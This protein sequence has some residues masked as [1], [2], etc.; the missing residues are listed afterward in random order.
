MP[1]ATVVIPSFDHGPTLLY[2][3]RSALAQ[4][5][6]DIEVFVVGDGVPDTTREIM[7]ELMREDDRVR[8]FDNPKALSRG[9][10]H[11]SSAL[12]EARGEIVCYLA[13]DDLWFPEHVEA[14]RNLLA[15]PKNTQGPPSPMS[16]KRR[17]RRHDRLARE[18]GHPI[19]DGR[20]KIRA[21]RY[22]NANLA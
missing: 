8:F 5:I 14:M 7:A 2:S 22:R 18:S 9:E 13:D 11:R 6:E 19:Q 4:T 10:L 12:E 15:R 20:F 16:R 1:Q 17:L 21:A 3:V